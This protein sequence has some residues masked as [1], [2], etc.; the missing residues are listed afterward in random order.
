V[1]PNSVFTLPNGV[2]F[3]VAVYKH[4]VVLPP[5]FV[6]GCTKLLE[7]GFHD[8]KQVEAVAQKLAEKN[9]DFVIKL[10]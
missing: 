8:A 1:T 6:Q 10:D 4:G 9:E 5:K 7:A 2:K 3:G